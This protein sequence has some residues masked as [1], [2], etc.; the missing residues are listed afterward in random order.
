MKSR[1]LAEI[2]LKS[3]D[4][5]VQIVNGYDELDNAKDIKEVYRLETIVGEDAPYIFLSIGG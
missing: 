5:V 2:L 3:P 4:A 1:D